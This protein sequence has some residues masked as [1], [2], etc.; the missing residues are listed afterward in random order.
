MNISCG[1]EDIIVVFRDRGKSL[2]PQSWQTRRVSVSK[3]TFSGR[4][5]ILIQSQE[6][7]E[8]KIDPWNQPILSKKL[9]LW[10]A[11][12]YLDPWPIDFFTLMYP[13]EKTT[14]DDAVCFLTDWCS[15]RWWWLHC[16]VLAARVGPRL[17]HQHQGP[18]AEFAS[19]KDF[20]SWWCSSLCSCVF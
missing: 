17:C 10:V 14:I 13:E 6:S 12:K 2:D 19:H 5:S 3:W 9:L 20:A 8:S 18:S 11:Q 4:F 1:R 15:D 7:V 16:Q